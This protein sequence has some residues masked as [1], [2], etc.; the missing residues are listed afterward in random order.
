MSTNCLS[1]KHWTPPKHRNDYDTIYDNGAD[2]K[3]GICEKIVLASR[4][5]GEEETPDPLPLAAVKDGSDYRA[6]LFTQATF[7]CAMWEASK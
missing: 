3:F 5:Y 2:L 7:S 4:S 1:C 6:I